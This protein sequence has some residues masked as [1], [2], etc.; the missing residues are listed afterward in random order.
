MERTLNTSYD[1][2][3]S[4]TR[5]M[6]AGTYGGYRLRMWSL[7]F[8]A[9]LAARLLAVYLGHL[10]GGE[11]FKFLFFSPGEI[12]HTLSSAL[13]LL[14]FIFSRLYPGIGINPAEEIKLVVRY[15]IIAFFT[16][17]LITSILRPNSA[18]NP[19]IPFFILAFSIITILL[20]R[21][22]VR[23]ISTQAGA[24]G[25]PVVV[26]ARGSQIDYLTRYFL[27]RRRLG[28]VPV[29]AATDSAGKKAITS[30]VPVVDLRRLLT[31][32]AIKDVH[33]ILVDASFFGRDL[34][35]SSYNKLTRTFKHVIFIS[36]M[37]WLEGASLAVRDFEGLTGIEARRDQLSSTKSIIKRG[38]D[39]L[40][41]LFGMLLFAPFM[42]VVM[43]LIKLDSPGPVFYSQERISMD[44]RKK[45]RLGADTRKI[46]IYKFR[47]MRVNAD[48][49]LAEH[50]AANPQARLEWDSTQKLQDDPRITR[51]G[52][53]LRKFS[54]DE[55][56]QLINVF[57]GEMSLV[58][59]RPMMTDQVEPYGQSFETYTGVRPGLTGFWQVSGRN[60]TTF[61]E[62]ARF[63]I[64]YVHNWSVWLDLYILTRTVW[65]VLSRDGA[66]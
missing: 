28:F 52:K 16:T 13:C 8:F 57:R 51:V 45:K 66:Y 3:I 17:V 58:G 60:T 31:D 26:L 53:W 35:N 27:T 49:A 10:A 40:G 65:V 21:W 62:R 19:A 37:G 15:S 30:S 50:L 7:M 12:E 32:S 33:T 59:P 44:R 63:D 2:L 46:F 20:M 48:Q 42:L 61:Q 5:K 55:I 64:Y 24:W 11:H 25:E 1:S 56:P 43:A 29:L 14:L 9:D 22:S 18:G 23:I 39:L 36:D 34:K 41:S 54:I 47:S 38:M 4:G 6:K